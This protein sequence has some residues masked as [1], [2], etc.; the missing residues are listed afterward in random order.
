VG[1][2]RAYGLLWSCCVFWACW[3]PLCPYLLTSFDWL[4]TINY[5]SPKNIIHS[6]ILMLP[7]LRIGDVLQTMRFLPR[8]HCLH[9]LPGRLTETS[10]VIE[11]DDISS[12]LGSRDVSV[13][14]R[15]YFR[16]FA[17]ACLIV[18][19]SVAWLD[20]VF[21]LR[22]AGS[23]MGWMDNCSSIS[24]SPLG[25]QSDF[26]WLWFFGVSGC[27]SRG[28]SDNWAFSTIC[29]PLPPRGHQ[30]QTRFLC[31]LF[32]GCSPK[33]IHGVLCFFAFVM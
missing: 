16:F 26:K 13:A 19:V 3:F 25:H 4:L 22:F 6:A 24:K 20:G 31:D 9:S 23:G 29:S 17:I 30:V 1:R 5:V 28:S 2:F 15:G 18:T 21:V 33:L 27:P 12:A 10:T 8:V 14:C 11:Y 32:L 7:S